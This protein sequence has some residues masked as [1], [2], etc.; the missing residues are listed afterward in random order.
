MVSAA[1]FLIVFEIKRGNVPEFFS[2]TLWLISNRTIQLIIYHVSLILLLVLFTYGITQLVRFL[3]IDT[4]T[5]CKDC[6][7]ADS[8]FLPSYLGYF[9]VALSV[10]DDCIC[11]VIELYLILV[12]FVYLAKAQ[13][14]NPMY[15][16]F[17]YHFYHVVTEKDRKLFCIIKGNVIHDSQ[18][19]NFDQLRRINNTTFITK[20]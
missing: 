6:T 4:I 2:D 9:F 17:G 18:D 19:I 11:I 8:D 13:Y 12:F 16:L 5:R 15:L 20:E 1:W 14:F 7:L 3:E 10:N